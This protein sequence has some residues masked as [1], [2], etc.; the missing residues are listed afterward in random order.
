MPTIK[1]CQTTNCYFQILA[2]NGGLPSCELG[3]LCGAA[4]VT[5]ATAS[6]VRVPPHDISPFLESQHVL[7]LESWVLG[8][9]GVDVFPGG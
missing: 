3:A 4:H 9:E 6:H 1:E 8:G 7:E 5:R 2:T